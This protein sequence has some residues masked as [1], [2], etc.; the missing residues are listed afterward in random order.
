MQELPRI[1]GSNFALFQFETWAA[2]KEPFIVADSQQIAAEAEKMRMALRK[3]RLAEAAHFEAVLDLRDAQTIR[4]QLLKDDLATI[5]INLSPSVGLVDLA[6]IPGDPPRLWI[7]PISYVVMEPNPQT[8]RFLQDTQAGR[9]IL[10]ETSDRAEMADRVRT[11]VAHRVVARERLLATAKSPEISPA[12]YSTGAMI[13]A[14]VSG[15]SIGVLAL[16]LV[17]VLLAHF[18]A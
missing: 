15:F 3:A 7:D 8:Y 11:H 10:Y 6:L 5:S 14:W 17:G 13:L 16:F 2:V 9:E 1:T 18:G 4:L 12:G